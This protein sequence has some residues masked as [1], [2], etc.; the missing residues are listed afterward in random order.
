M[1]NLPLAAV[2][3]AMLTIAATSVSS[4]APADTV[5][6]PNT[7]VAGTPAKAAD[8]NANFTAVAG[9]INNTA[10][11]VSALQTTVQNIPPA[12]Q[13]LQGP[14][15]PA[16]AQGPVGAQGAK[17]AN[18]ATGPAGPTGPAG[19][20]GP[21]GPAGTQGA[22]GAAGALGPQG[23]IGATGPTGSM[24]PQGAAATSISVY[25]ANNVLVGQWFPGGQ[26]LITS[27]S[28]PFY[29]SAN[30]T[31]FVYDGG[32]YFTTS[33]CSGTPYFWTGSV[34]QL[35]PYA[36]LSAPGSSTVYVPGTVALTIGIN[37]GLQPDNTCYAAQFGTPTVLPV[38]AIELPAFA[39]P[40]SVH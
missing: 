34:P 29:T 19:A 14:Q 5:T 30:A 32:L 6:I 40:F 35:I 28:R 27:Q 37:S 2:V 17:G 38:I 25:D 7:F 23:P 15:G 4:G 9:A 16:G 36:V 11:T 10:Q 3:A 20:A 12:P 24:G 13:G 21:M 18:G 39:T 1:P 22:I 26:V 33:D 8:V 31:G